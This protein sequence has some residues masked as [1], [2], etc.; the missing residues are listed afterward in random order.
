[1]QIDGLISRSSV[2]NLHETADRL[3][4]VLNSRGLEIMARIDHAAA[5]NKVGLALRPTEL[6]IFG[7]PKSGTP[8][9]QKSQTLGIDLPLKALLWEDEAGIVWISYNEPGWLARRHGIDG[10]NEATVRAMEAA[11]MAIA[12]EAAD[13]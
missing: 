5:A 3:I 6:F 2:W 7:N 10:E 11:M 13:R 4:A 12:K 8:L 9:M 1:M